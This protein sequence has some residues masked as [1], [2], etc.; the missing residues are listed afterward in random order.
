MIWG[1]QEDDVHR[2]SAN[3]M[4]FLKESFSWVESA[5]HKYLRSRDIKD[6]EGQLKIWLEVHVCVHVHII[7]INNIMSYKLICRYGPSRNNSALN[8]FCKTICL[9]SSHS[10]N[11]ETV[12]QKQSWEQSAHSSHLPLGLWFQCAASV[13]DL[14]PENLQQSCFLMN[15]T[16][17]VDLFIRNNID[18]KH[19]FPRTI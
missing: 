18:R 9:N 1:I 3:I 12:G 5:I 16:G 11:F 15:C 10:C 14:R 19:T 17:K 2:L 4:L 13:G 7:W 6:A 8:N